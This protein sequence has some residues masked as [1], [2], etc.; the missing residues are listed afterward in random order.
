MAD[1]RIAF[2]RRLDIEGREWDGVSKTDD[3]CWTGGKQGVGE[4]IGCKFGIIATELSKYLGRTATKEDMQN[5]T[6]DIA[7]EIEKPKYW[8]EFRGDEIVNQGIANDLYDAC[9]NQGEVTGIDE[10]QQA[11]GL[12]VTGKMDNNTLANLNNQ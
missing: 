1:F 4:F 6:E 2:N 5:L 11:A 9:F 10:L 3:G 12:P 7:Y 8:D